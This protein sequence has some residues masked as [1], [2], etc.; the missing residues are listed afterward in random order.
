MRRLASGVALAACFF[1]SSPVSADDPVTNLVLG[2]VENKINDVLDHATADGDFL[3]Q[4]LAQQALAVIKAWKESNEA[5]INTAFDRLDNS[6]QQLFNDM[7]MT[8]S[9][10]ET[11]E[12]IAMQDAETLSANWSG[13]IKDLPFTNHDPEVFDYYPRVISPVGGGTIPIHIV[14]PK[15]ASA[16]PS[17]VTEPTTT[18]VNLGR[19]TEGQLIANLDRSKLAFDSNASNLVSYKLTFSAVTFSWLKPSTWG[20]SDTTS[21]DI[22]VW[23]LPKNMAAYTI[24]PTVESAHTEN[25]S[26]HQSVT[27]RGKDSGSATTITV[28]TVQATQGWTIDVTKVAAGGFWSNPAQS[29]GSS[30]TGPDQHSIT[31]QSFAFDAQLGHETDSFGHKSDG[32]VDCEL[33]VPLIRTVRTSVAG[34][35]LNGTLT[36]TDDALVSLPPNTLSYVLR[37]KMF[38]GRSYI[39]QPTTAA[40]YGV[41]EIMRQPGSI[42]FR[43][44]PPRDF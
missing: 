19:A 39:L 23:L 8:F 29:G 37:L 32:S 14:G 13:V 31:P 44:H 11:D 1:I 33:N 43:P 17:M 36:W 35:D 2:G 22:T 42:Q 25:S 27:P 41:V 4:R 10:L 21:R 12:T 18:P 28:P 3:I 34:D 20:K 30:C 9:R 38:D 16:D 15:L 24:S 6:T 7:N 40:P 26:F 5:L